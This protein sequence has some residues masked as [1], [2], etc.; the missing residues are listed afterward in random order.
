MIPDHKGSRGL[1]TTFYRLD[2]DDRIIEVGGA[3]DAFALDN[4]GDEAV[5]DA[6]LGTS[7]WSNVTGDVARMYMEA[8]LIRA[9]L[10]NTPITIDY[11]CNSPTLQRKSRMVLTSYGDGS[12]M[13]AHQI[14]R[15]QPLLADASS[16]A[17]IQRLIKACA[18]CRRVRFKGKWVNAQDVATL[19]DLKQFFGMCEDCKTS[20]ERGLAH[21]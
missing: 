15:V 3:W 5:A 13:S 1:A 9:R 16:S 2:A 8:I 21:L 11:F 14:L 20:R 12:V 19:N 10:E 18:I 7:I 6:V 17:E 4:N